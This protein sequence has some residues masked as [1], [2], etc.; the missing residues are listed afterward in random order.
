METTRPPV[1]GISVVVPV[2]N[3]DRSV[4]ELVERLEPV[5]ATDDTGPFEAIL[6]N[7]GSRDDS[8]R[9]ICELA[10]RLPWVHGIDLMR[11]YGQHNALLCG[12]RA[13]SYRWIITMDD[14]LQHPPDQI[15]LLL[16]KLNEGYDVVYGVPERLSHGLVRNLMSRG[17]KVLVA[18]ATGNRNIRDLNAFRAIRAD[19]RP[20]LTPFESPALLLDVLLGWTTSRFASVTVH[21]EPRRVGSSNYSPLRLFNQLLLICTS[22]TT[23]PLRM[24]SMIGFC[25]TV[26]G[27][28]LMAYVL[29]RTLLEG[30]EPG[31]PFLASIITIFGGVQLFSLGVIGEYLGRMFERTMNRPTYVIRTATADAESS[32][33]RGRQ[34]RQDTCRR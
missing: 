6:V 14:D 32:D 22:Y 9:V 5:L 7:D 26:F 34:V 31:F 28:C 4:A 8:W 20:S 10:R 30:S 27:F 19:L 29:V 16:A 1:D 17:A 12:I 15:P 24:S 11:N 21:Q 3:G 13:A 18:K 25:F 33:D 2:F 23:F